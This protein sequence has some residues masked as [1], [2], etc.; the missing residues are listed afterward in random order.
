VKPRIFPWNGDRDP[1]QLDRVQDIGGDLTLN[2][3]KVYEVGREEILGYRKGTPEFAYSMR[4]FEYGSMAFW[5]ALANQED[6]ASAALDN[7]ITLE[8]I[9]VT[10]SDI[11][12]YLT[13]DNGTFRGT[14]WFPN[15]RVNGFSIN[16]ADP[17]SIVERNFDLVGEDYKILDG[18]YFRFQKDT[19]VGSGAL[20][21]V[22]S[23]TPVQY[24][25]GDYVFR[26][27][28]VRGADVTELE[29]DTS[30]PYATNTWRY[31]VGTNSV[32]TQSCAASDIVKIYYPSNTSYTVW[33]DND[34]DADFLLAEQCEIW[35]KNG[36]GS[37]ARIYRLQGITIDVTLDRTDYKEIGN[38]QVVQTGVSGKTVTI[39]L[40]SLGEDF[41]LEDILNSDPT[42]PYID[43]RDFPDTIQLQ[44]KIYTDKTHSTFKMGYLVQNLSPTTL[45]LSQTVE[46]YMQ[47]NNA[48]ESD[49]LL[50]SDDETEIAF[51]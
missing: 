28:R 23:V 21:T 14:V 16:I 43:P 49:N 22:L 20:T 9:K 24:A 38:S 4:Q 36:T 46:D 34:S 32:I 44:V 35:M 29:E 50:I 19:A 31:D 12:A 17:D 11:S 1:E 15:L 51:A 48:L 33:N 8:D 2:R 47:K 6:P 10:R 45:G 5:R 40:N 3:E 27:L 25:S 18:N 39:T 26:V 41:T 7:S 37:D 30:S 13:D 42:Y